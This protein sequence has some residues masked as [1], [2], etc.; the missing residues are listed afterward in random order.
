MP[1]LVTVNIWQDK[2]D[3]IV[4]VMA[5]YDDRWVKG[6][7]P[8]AVPKA[9]LDFCHSAKNHDSL[10]LSDGRTLNSFFN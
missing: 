3:K 2:D 5:A 1:K 6:F 8:N 9:V 4:K 10:T 7:D